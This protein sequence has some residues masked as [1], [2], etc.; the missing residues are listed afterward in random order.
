[1]SHI[2]KRKINIP[3]NVDFR[4]E[5][6]IAR[7]KGPKGEISVEIPSVL[8]F[9]LEAKEFFLF[10]KSKEKKTMAIWGLINALVSN[11]VKGAVSGFSRQLEIKGVGYRASV[12]GNK[13]I[14][15]LGFSHPMEITAPQGI[16]F[17][18][19][20]NIITVSGID[21]QLV[22]EIAAKIRDM[23][24]PEPYKGKGI[25]YVGEYVRQKAGKKAIGSGF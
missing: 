4:I 18:V 12:Q 15:L 6:N 2:G 21:N 9:K 8:E 23:K 10:P 3:D 22:G 16:A 13:L 7:V 17:N 20:K 11:A 24:K 5:A 25:R 14:L 19:E 1:M